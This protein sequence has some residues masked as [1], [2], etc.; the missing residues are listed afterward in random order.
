MQVLLE[1]DYGLNNL[2]KKESVYTW[3]GGVNTYSSTFTYEFN[4]NNYPTKQIAKS[5]NNG[6]DSPYEETS[7]YEYN[8]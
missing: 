4:K 1:S 6:S 3:S 5:N 2:V 7:L 8:R